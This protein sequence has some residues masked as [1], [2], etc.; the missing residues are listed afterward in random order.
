[1]SELAFVVVMFVVRVETVAV[2]DELVADAPMP[3]AQ[4]L[5]PTPT[6]ALNVVAALNVTTMLWAAP[7]AGLS[8]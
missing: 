2:N 8:R 1:M 3:V 4:P 5:I 7:V 6:I